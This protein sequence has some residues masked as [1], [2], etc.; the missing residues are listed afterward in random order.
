MKKGKRE[1]ITM[2]DNGIITIPNKVRM[3]IGEITDLFGI[4]YRTAKRYIHAI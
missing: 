4:Y 2:T 3:N 1:I